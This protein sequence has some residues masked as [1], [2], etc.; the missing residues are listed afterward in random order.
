MTS[1]ALAIPHTPWVPE[2]VESMAKLRS[3]LG[4]IPGPYREFTDKAPNHVWSVQLWTW[5]YETGAEW[6]LQLQ[7][8][9]MVA[10]CFWPALRAQL[11][12]L[13]EDADVIGLTSVHPMTPEI[14]R[15]GHRWHRTEAN[16]V[17]WAYAL[18]REALG[19][20][21]ASERAKTNEDEQIAYWTRASGRT[22]WHP[23]PAI[24]DHDTTIPSSYAND[25][26]SHRRPQVTWRTFDEK[27]LTSA[28]WW[29]PSGVPE[30]LP[31]PAQ[32]Q[33]W[34][35]EERPIKGQAKNGVGI[36]E[37]C[38]IPAAAAALSGMCC[39]CLKR[40]A[41]RGSQASGFGVCGFCVHETSGSII[42]EYETAWNRAQSK[43]VIVGGDE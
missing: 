3:A 10:P 15:R 27:D 42:G 28:D 24:V 17:G 38:S 7:D 5:L 11:D 9:V 39:L 40:R 32:R 26:H 6:C 20:F 35:C 25:H 19:E 1:I 33:C 2:R 13:P 12:A 4:V 18:R 30:L 41:I 8:D 31:M 22:V 21:L 34:M 23:V 14:A 37:Q 43:G 36:C 16:L 29:L